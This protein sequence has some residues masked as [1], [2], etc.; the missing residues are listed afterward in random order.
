MKLKNIWLGLVILII[1]VVLIFIFRNL[2][3][4]KNSISNYSL[5]NEVSDISLSSEEIN[6]LYTTLND[7]YK[8]EAIYQKVIDKFGN[9]Q[10]FVSIM[11]A[12]QKHSFSL[13]I[14]FNKYNLEIPNNDWYDKVSEYNSV[15]EACQAGVIAEIENAALYDEMIKNINHEDIIVVFN[16]LKNASLEK[17]LPA[18]EKCS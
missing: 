8:A 4:Q 13:I 6:A 9:V 15:S 5:T 16:A 7:E 12:E 10:P 1:I 2:I 18:F 3:F 11:S 14:L 17:H